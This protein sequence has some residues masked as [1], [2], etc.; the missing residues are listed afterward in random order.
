MKNKHLSYFN[1]VRS[2]LSFGLLALLF[3]LNAPVASAQAVRHQSDF[4][5]L[6]T[7]FPLTGSHVRVECETCHTGGIFKGTPKDCAGC[8]SVG[9][10]VIA[11]AKPSNHMDTSAPCDTCHTNTVT[12]T[13]ARFNHMGVQPKACMTCHTGIHAPGKPSG[14]V[15]TMSSCDSC[16]RTSS[17]IPAGFN[18]TGTFLVCANCHNGTNAIGKPGFHI[19]T[20]D[21]CDT[22]HKSGFTTFAGAVYS[23]PSP[24]VQPG[25]CGTCHIPGTYREK[26]KPSGH[27][28]YTGNNCD[29][30]HVGTGYISFAGS[31]MNHNASGLVGVPCSTCHNGSYTS[32]GSFLGGAKAKHSG[33]VVTTAECN[34]CH[35]GFIS[36]LGGAFNHATATPPVAGICGTCHNGT[37][38]LGK[39][40]THITTSLSCDNAGCHGNTTPP[41]NN[42]TSFAGL[43]FNH[44]GV[45]AGTCGTCHLGQKLPS[46]F[47]KTQTH[48]PTTGNACDACHLNT[49]SFANPTMNHGSVTAVSCS[50][51]HN[52][53]YTTEGV[54]YGGALAKTPTHIATSATCNSCHHS[55][56]T[57]TGVVY[58]HSGVTPTTCGSCHL[59]GIGGAKQKTAGH[60][61]TTSNACDAC[62]KTGYASFVNPTMSHLAVTVYRCDQC[63]N[64]SYLTEGTQLGGAKAKP[65]GNGHIPTT[66]TG[67]LDCNTCHTSTTSWLSEKMNHNGALG[68][69]GV[70][71]TTCHV[72]GA[73]YPGNMQKKSLTH[74]SGGHIDC[75]DSGCHKPLGSKG[76]SWVK[77]N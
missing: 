29:T 8:H 72:S 43:T 51:C 61:P 60:I 12:F 3:A 33:H 71:C 64:G 2:I 76:T 75:S 32:Q 19:P 37:K 27:I 13:G 5:H 20:S 73:P 53:S 18:H 77:W 1:F 25:N 55:F 9:R 67:T 50:T 52:G 4:N 47:T 65:A 42:Y 45:V 15:V 6:S 40:A 56:T 46:A 30:C 68:K 11:P 16:H 41:A 14:H 31:T 22:C 66:I 35:Q 7:G 10:R 62:H 63:H 44:T 23:H 59:T 28:P 34:T 74:D 57:F 49:T 39:P 26:T 36:F 21:A 54:T 38:A 48:I 58:D 69:T 24:T 17:W 70:L